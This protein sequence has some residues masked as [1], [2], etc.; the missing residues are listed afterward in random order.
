MKYNKIKSVP[1]SEIKLGL[2]LAKNIHEISST[3][4]CYSIKIKQNLCDID[5]A[6]KSFNLEQILNC[7]SLIAS[8]YG[9]ILIKSGKF[10][11][12]T[13]SFLI[14]QGLIQNFYYLKNIGEEL[15]THLHIDNLRKVLLTTSELIANYILDKLVEDFNYQ[16]LFY[17]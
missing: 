13:K 3:D 11:Y 10:S 17:S 12:R 9:H 6:L 4:T 8:Q 5:N 2:N 14:E 1:I 16:A 15:K 7:N